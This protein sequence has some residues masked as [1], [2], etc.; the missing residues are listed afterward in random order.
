[1]ASS[2]ISSLLRGSENE[3]ECQ[4]DQRFTETA[5]RGRREQHETSSPITLTHSR[6]PARKTQ[7][8]FC[9]FQENDRYSHWIG[10]ARTDG[11]SRTQYATSWC[12]ARHAC[13]RNISASGALLERSRVSRLSNASRCR[14]GCVN[15][16][17]W[18]SFRSPLASCAR[19]TTGSAS[20]GASH[21]HL[22]SSS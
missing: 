22:L 3:R 20:N 21:C 8:L 16:A 10:P 19:P 13:L 14:S 12:A 11:L 15:R 5:Q 9:C 18:L 4:E 7:R 2:E 6:A 1:L 17:A